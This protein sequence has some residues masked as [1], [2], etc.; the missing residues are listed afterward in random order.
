MQT[1]QMETFLDGTEQNFASM[2]SGGVSNVS[3]EELDRLVNEQIMQ[4]GLGDEEIDKQ[5][6]E[7][8]K[9]LENK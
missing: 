9:M 3:Q 7:I 6:A 4:D 8:K 2:S 5:L 1:A